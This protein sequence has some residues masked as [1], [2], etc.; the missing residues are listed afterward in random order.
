M[1]RPERS[2]CSPTMRSSVRQPTLEKGFKVQTVFRHRVRWR[3]D[4]AR[5]SHYSE[6]IRAISP[7]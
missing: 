7:R 6:V 1:F 3:T 5:L 2:F 4:E